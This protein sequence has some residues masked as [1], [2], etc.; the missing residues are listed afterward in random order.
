MV[1]VSEANG[2]P[3]K[4]PESSQLRANKAAGRPEN[5]PE[6]KLFAGLRARDGGDSASERHCSVSTR[7]QPAPG[8]R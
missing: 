2:R 5:G 3:Q 6:V 8:R 4:C 7:R 1:A